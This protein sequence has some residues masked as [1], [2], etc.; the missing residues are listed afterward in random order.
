[1]KQGVEVVRGDWKH[2]VEGLLPHACHSGTQVHPHNLQRPAQLPFRPVR[3]HTLP[4]PSAFP[5]PML[6]PPQGTLL[7][8]VAL[9]EAKMTGLSVG[10]RNNE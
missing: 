7:C 1:M 10:F 9:A 4:L 3:C 5:S 2:V 6:S 8:S